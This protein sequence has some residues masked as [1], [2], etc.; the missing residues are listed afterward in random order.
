[1][2]RVPAVDASE[3]QECRCGEVGRGRSFRVVQISRSLQRSLGTCPHCGAGILGHEIDAQ[4]GYNSACIA[5]VEPVKGEAVVQQS[6]RFT[7]YLAR[8]LEIHLGPF[9]GDRLCGCQELIE[10]WAHRDVRH[11]ASLSMP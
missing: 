10:R 4:P 9:L 11:A 1:M 5:F 3:L 7:E 8:Q 6:R 2:Q